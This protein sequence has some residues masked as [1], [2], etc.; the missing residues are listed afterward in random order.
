MEKRAP[1]IVT[2]ATRTMGKHFDE[3]NIS[4][5]IA[6]GRAA[7]YVLRCNLHATVVVELEKHEHHYT[8]KQYKKLHRYF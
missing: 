2:K 1:G 3:G 8:N 4:V 6:F 7:A 5:Y